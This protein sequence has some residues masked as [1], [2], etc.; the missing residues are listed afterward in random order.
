MTT[1]PPTPQPVVADTDEIRRACA[2]LVEP[3]GVV[4]LRALNVDGRS[5][6]T[7]S[8]YYDDPDALVRDVVQLSGRAPGLYLTM[9]TIDP[10]LLARYANRIET[11]AKLATADHNVTRRRWVLVDLD[12]P[13]PSGTSANEA[14]HAAA[15]AAVR[16][17]WT[18]LKAH[19]VPAQAL[20]VIDSGNGAHLLIR[21]DL[22]NDDEALRLVERVL[23][24][25]ALYL[26]TEAVTVDLKVANAARIVKLPGTLTAKGDALPD[27]PHRLA[28]ILHA[29]APDELEICPTEIIE[30]IAQTAPVATPRARSGR[31]QA[32]Q[33]DFDLEGWIVEH[34]IDVGPPLPWKDGTKWIFTVCPWNSDHANDDAYILRFG[35]GAIAAGCQHNGC[36]GN[37]WRELRMLYEP[38]AYSRSPEPPRTP[39]DTLRRNHANAAPK[40]GSQPHAAEEPIRVVRL[41]PASAITPRPVRWTMYD[42]LPEGELAMTAGRGGVGKSTFHTWLTAGLT[43]GEIPGAHL[44]T[45]RA[46]IVAAAEDSWAR[47][48]V[49]RLIAAGAD[50]ERVFR[51]DVVTEE[52]DELSLTLPADSEALEAEIARVGAAMLSIDPLMSTVAVDL[53]THKDRDVRRALEPLAHLA[54]RTGCLVLGNG[55]FNKNTTDPLA[56]VMGSAAFANVVRAALGFAVDPDDGSHVISQIKNNLGRLD[57]PSLSYEI[58]AATIVTPEGPAEVGRLVMTGEAARSVADILRD[59][60]DEEERTERSDVQRW[61]IGYLDGAGGSARATDTIAAGNAAG[62]TKHVIKKARIAIK[63]RTEKAGYA[64]DAYW[65]W[66]LDSLSRSS[67][68]VEGAYI[69]EPGTFDTF[70]APSDERDSESGYVCPNCGKRIEGRETACACGWSPMR[71]VAL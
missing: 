55:H 40:N 15:H 41:T 21:V 71:E 57:L 67:E 22:P 64:P 60:A 35:D 38:N 19:G 14:E 37:G 49:P 61:L 29:P 53:D 44:G 10:A 54:D 46:V 20:V 24:A 23:A 39:R 36:I 3:G 17:A 43:R 30:R 45:P 27:R 51:A 70:G 4:E 66:T 13:R 68:G 47:T 11:Y 2:L 7:D 12:P 18:W 1:A 26:D 56:A 65:S 25:A 9:N 16:R 52:G 8:G 31:G 63:A 50:L 62:F 6:R 58:E 33:G 59:R 48:I 69:P 34:G 28:R 32:Q 5:N 42:R